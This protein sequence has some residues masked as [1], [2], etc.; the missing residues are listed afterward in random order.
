MSEC[1]I[2]NKGMSGNG[3]GSFCENGKHQPAH[4]Y[5]YETKVG[6]I[7]EGL[8][9][10]HLCRNRA[11]VNVDHLEPVTQRENLRR[12]AQAMWD[13]RD[14]KCKNGHAAEKILSNPTTGRKTCREC[15]S[16]ANKK[17]KDKIR[18]GKQ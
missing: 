17:Q 1:K 13:A 18:S 16:I 7:P 15:K 6:P 8:Q 14:G 4:R 5:V 10:D 12:G 3:Y 11:C 9:I 2:W